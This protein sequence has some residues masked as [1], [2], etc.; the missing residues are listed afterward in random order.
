MIDILLKAGV[1]VNATDSVGGTA[2]HY[3]C[4]KHSSHCAVTQLLE[5]GALV[6]VMSAEG[7]E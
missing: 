5:A 1:S 3:A 7:T 4:S 2:L 6:N